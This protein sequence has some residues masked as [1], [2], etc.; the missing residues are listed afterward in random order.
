[1]LTKGR[2]E[3]SECGVWMVNPSHG[4]KL[5]V[6]NVKHEEDTVLSSWKTIFIYFPYIPLCF[7]FFSSSLCNMMCVQWGK[8]DSLVALRISGETKDKQHVGVEILPSSVLEKEHSHA[9]PLWEQAFHGAAYILHKL[10]PNFYSLLCPHI[11]GHLICTSY[12]WINMCHHALL[13]LQRSIFT[14]P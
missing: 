2:T 9:S 14:M 3:M 1:M 4:T 5:I 6:S 11:F 12:S 10:C 8:H 13:Y 7:F